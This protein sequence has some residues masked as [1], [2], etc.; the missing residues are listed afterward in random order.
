MP[1]RLV[2]CSL[3]QPFFCQSFKLTFVTDDEQLRLP[4]N[5]LE[6]VVPPGQFTTEVLRR[7]NGRV[8]LPS[9]FRLGVDEGRNNH[10]ERDVVADNHQIDIARRGLAPFCNGAIDEGNPDLSLDRFQ[11]SSENLRDTKGLP[12]KAAKFAE[13]REL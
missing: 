4:Q 13:D 6:K 5:G 8:D 1:K 3:S 11:A 7:I 12:N 10:F 9:E 2:L